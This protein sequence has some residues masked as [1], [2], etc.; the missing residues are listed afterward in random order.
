MLGTLEEVLIPNKP[1]LIE[2][3]GHLKELHDKPG[4]GAFE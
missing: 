4:E 1:R 2:I 3:L